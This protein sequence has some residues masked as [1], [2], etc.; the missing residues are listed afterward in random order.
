MIN[1]EEYK[2]NPRKYYNQILE[3]I[4]QLYQNLLD[5]YNQLGNDKNTLKFISSISEDIAWIFNKLE[6]MEGLNLLIKFDDKNKD[7]Y[8]KYLEE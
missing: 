2:K 7:N 1:T 3:I 6:I 8:L 5:I 4:R